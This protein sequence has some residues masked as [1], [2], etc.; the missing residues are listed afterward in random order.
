MS[1]AGKVTTPDALAVAAAGEL[2][3]SQFVVG[4]QLMSVVGDTVALLDEHRRS[5]PGSR[6][7]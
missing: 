7:R 4:S 5:P 3:R 2:P 1:F 6:S